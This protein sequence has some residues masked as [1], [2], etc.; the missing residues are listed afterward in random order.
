MPLLATFA[1][2]GQ[3]CLAAGNNC[4]ATGITGIGGATLDWVDYIQDNLATPSIPMRLVTRTGATL[5]LNNANL[6]SGGVSGE[7]FAL[8]LH[9]II[10]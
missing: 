1:Y 2:A 4:L 6:P 3:F 10:R 7:V 5:I 9:S 8:Y